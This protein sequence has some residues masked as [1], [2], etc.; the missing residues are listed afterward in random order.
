MSVSSLVTWSMHQFTLKLSLN[1][2]W[3]TM[4]G[5]LKPV[6]IQ[7]LGLF[8][9]GRLKWDSFSHTAMVSIY[10][11]VGAVIFCD[12]LHGMVNTKLCPICTH[13]ECTGSIPLAMVWAADTGDTF[14]QQQRQRPWPVHLGQP[15]PFLASLRGCQPSPASQAGIANHPPQQVECCQGC[16]LQLPVALLRM[17]CGNCE[18]PNSQNQM[19]M[20]LLVK[21]VY[22]N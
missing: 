4:H 15:W 22:L 3:L 21:H 1:E 16:L 7:A 13:S 18:T 6:H 20:Q 12:F 8:F 11:S 9:K 14:W 2:K 10:I 17:Q 19:P 5:T